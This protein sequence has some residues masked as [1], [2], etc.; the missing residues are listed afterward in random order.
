MLALPVKT[1]MF[2]HANPA[3]S[4]ANSLNLSSF[5]THT[6]YICPYA[7]ILLLSA[8]VKTNFHLVIMVDSNWVKNPSPAL[9]VFHILIWYLGVEVVL[10]DLVMMQL[11]PCTIRES[12]VCTPILYG[13]GEYILRAISLI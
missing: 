5:H 10:F 11:R 7:S 4:N 8:L 3:L 13:L 1:P 6:G 12:L 2:S 9:R